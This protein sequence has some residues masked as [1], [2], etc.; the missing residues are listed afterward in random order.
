[1]MFRKGGT[2]DRSHESIAKTPGSPLA[3]LVR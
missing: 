2:Y 1:M 3:D